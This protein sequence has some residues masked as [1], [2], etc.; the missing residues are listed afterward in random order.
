LI[1][2][3]KIITKWSFRYYFIKNKEENSFVFLKDNETIVRSIFK[4]LDFYAFAGFGGLAYKVK[5]N[6]IYHALNFT[7]TYKIKKR[8]KGSPAF[9]K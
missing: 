2:E 5:P 7:L 4:S 9:G 6:D 8:E 3:L 1:A